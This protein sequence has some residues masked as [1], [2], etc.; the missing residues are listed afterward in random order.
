MD[1]EGYI[2]DQNI[3]KMR[4]LGDESILNREYYY[5]TITDNNL[6]KLDLI[7]DLGILSKNEQQKS[8]L[9]IPYASEQYDG[10]EAY[11]FLT[12]FSSKNSCY[13]FSSQ[14]AKNLMKKISLVISNE[15]LKEVKEAKGCYYPLYSDEVLI[16]DKVSKDNIIGIIIPSNLLDKQVGELTSFGRNGFCFTEANFNNYLKLMNSY[17]D[18]A[19]NDTEIK[20]KFTSIVSF[21]NTCKLRDDLIDE[22]SEVSCHRISGMSFLLY[23]SSIM[24]ECWNKKLGLNYNA[25]VRDVIIYIKEKHKNLILFNE[26]GLKYDNLKVIKEEASKRFTK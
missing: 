17:F 1:S 5:H 2:F 9:L 13:I 6:I 26:I 23:L 14:I 4:A 25:T 11:V 15:S 21:L 12:K 3:L 8:D 10:N 7:L 24:Q 20:K 16:Q 18:T 19:I 22:I